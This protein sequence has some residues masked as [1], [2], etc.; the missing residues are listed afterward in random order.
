MCEKPEVTYLQTR[1][2]AMSYPFIA[3]PSQVVREI[4]ENQ[5]DYIIVDAFGLGDKLPG[6]E[7]YLKPVVEK[8][9]ERFSL[10]FKTLPPENS[11]YQVKLR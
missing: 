3:D 11:V 6:V 4:K 2:K 10:K 1:R 9:P 5:I 7:T 8:Y